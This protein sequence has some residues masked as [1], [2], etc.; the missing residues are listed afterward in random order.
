MRQ[1]TPDD[2]LYRWHREALIYPDIARH[3][4]LP[5]AGWYR[6]QL[7][8]GGPWVAVEIWCERE[9]HRET[10]ELETPERIVGSANGNLLSRD[11]LES[12][13]TR[14]R[15]I[16]RDDYAALLRRIEQTPAMHNPYHPLD[17]AK[18]A[19]A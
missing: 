6:M 14:M 1:P 13:W 7:V 18:G 8:K 19:A 9:I 3:D 11:D 16:S 17:A 12:A 5:E 2:V 4:G 15:A 10:G